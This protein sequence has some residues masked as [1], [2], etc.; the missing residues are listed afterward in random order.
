MTP[1]TLT[2]I[3]YSK[4]IGFCVLILPLLFLFWG[5]VCSIKLAN[6]QYLTA[7]NYCITPYSNPTLKT[8]KGKTWLCW[9]LDAF[10]HSSFSNFITTQ[11]DKSCQSS[12]KIILLPC[13]FIIRLQT[14][15]CY[16]WKKMCSIVIQESVDGTKITWS[17]GRFCWL[18]LVVG[19]IFSDLTLV[20]C[21][22]K[23]DLAC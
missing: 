11:R 20:D 8:C 18:A 9:E 13:I 19:V 10:S 12:T 22:Q 1:Q 2:V 15:A 14:T 5:S 6:S 17:S 23:G 21:W 16:F 3:V 7:L 4:H